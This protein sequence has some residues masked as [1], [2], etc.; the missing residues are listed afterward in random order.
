MADLTS[1]IS[2]T[3]AG[4]KGLAAEIANSVQTYAGMWA[5]LRGPDHATSQGYLDSYDDEKGMIFAGGHLGDQKLGD[6]SA[7][8]VPENR[9]NTEPKVYKE[10]AV[11]GVASRADIGKAVYAT[12]SD[13]LTLTRPTLGTPIGVVVEWHSGTS[14]DVLFLGLAAQ[15]AVDLSGQACQ[16]L[17]LGH[18]NA[19]E[20]ADG[21]I[22]TSYPFPCHAE[23]VSFYAVCEKALAGSGGTTTLNLEIGTTNVTGDLA[24]TT[25]AGT[26]GAVI[27][28]A[29]SGSNVAHAGDALS[30]EAS[31]TSSGGSAISA[32]EFDLYIKIVPR[33]GV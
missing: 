19:A 16:V 9:W 32:G 29:Q 2:R 20:I 15:A 10:L 1:S 7:S 12:D 18:F 33:L 28:A 8:P 6:T 26:K 11:T 22:V 24:I 30:V 13:A 5:G 3:V 23:I 27:S 31:S 14:C 4:A 25:V 21:D 17:H